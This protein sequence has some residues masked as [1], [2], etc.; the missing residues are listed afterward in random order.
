MV[1]SGFIGCEIAASLR[2]TGHPV[3]LVSD[4]PAPNAARLGDEAGERIAGWL[5]EE[6]VVLRL[7]A[8]V[9]RIASGDAGAVV[10]AAHGSA[11]GEVVVMATGIA[12]RSGLA[13]AAGT[14]IADD[15]R[16]ARGRRRCGPSLEGVLAA[17]D[18][19]L[20][21]NAAAGRP[22]R[23]EHWGDALAQGEVAGRT[24]AGAPSTW[25]DV[26]GFWS[27]IG[28]RTLKHAAW[29]DGFDEVRFEPHGG[30][31]FTAWYGAGGRLVG[32]L[33]HEAR[34]RTTSAA[35][36]WSPRAR[37]GEPRSGALSSSSRPATRPRA[38]APASRRW[39]RSA[40][41]RLRFAVIVVLDGCRDATGRVAAGA[42]A[43]HGLD[44][45]AGPGAPAG[46]GRRAPRG[47][48][49]RGGTAARCR[50]RSTG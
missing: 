19:A 23:V 47:D 7:G 40:S 42:A 48:G 12:P 33:A 18:V 17:G 41:P 37:R 35:A 3:T 29:G 21:H 38:S 6:G 14:A 22:L 26:P 49:A 2:R 24:A 10:H 30:G 4:E 28:S 1:G 15:G 31:G 39:P 32:V 8:A 43:S 50:P 13:E 34:R 27:S 36:S 16:G 9:E 45:R 46:R 5:E 44:L 20:A 25:A 11:E